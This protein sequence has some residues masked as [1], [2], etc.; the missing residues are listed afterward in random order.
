MDDEKLFYQLFYKKKYIIVKQVDNFLNTE[1]NK[2]SKRNLFLE[3][4]H[5][6]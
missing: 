6:A 2:D 5:E 3:I 1:Y 4:G